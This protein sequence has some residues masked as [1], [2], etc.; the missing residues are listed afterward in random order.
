MHAAAEGGYEAIV[1]TLLDNGA[2]VDAKVGVISPIYAA[3]SR[4]HRS[5]VQFLLER[6]ANT[7]DL[8]REAINVVAIRALLPSTNRSSLAYL[9][10]HP[11]TFFSFP[12][13]L[14]F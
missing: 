7:M 5:V 8:Y 13:V 12:H 4:E 6:G 2:D 10:G 9:S 3:A 1:A 11:P 14:P